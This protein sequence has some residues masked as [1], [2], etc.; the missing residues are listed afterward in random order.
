ML[1]GL[2]FPPDYTVILRT[3]SP[4]FKRSAL[5]LPAVHFRRTGSAPALLNFPKETQFHRARRR[6]VN[7]YFSFSSA[8]HLC[9]TAVST[10]KPIGTAQ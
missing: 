7:P 9:L 8:G 3:P 2:V 4:L 6:I 5:K 1:Y 10:G